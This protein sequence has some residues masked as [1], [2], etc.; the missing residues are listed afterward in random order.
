[1]IIA[2]SVKPLTQIPLF[3]YRRTKFHPTGLRP[4]HPC[5]GPLGNRA[6]DAVVSTRS[7]TKNWRDCRNSSRFRN[8]Q[9]P[10]AFAA[11]KVVPK[12]GCEDL[13]TGGM[14]NEKGQFMMEGI[15]LGPNT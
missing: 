4:E 8:R 15:T 12:N 3:N 14:S 7:K 13:V 6:V 11:I 10:L 9:E 5:H 1:M 2:T